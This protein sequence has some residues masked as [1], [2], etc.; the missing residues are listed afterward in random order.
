MKKVALF[1]CYC[2]YWRYSH[3]FIL[4][5]GD[6]HACSIEG[7]A[8]CRSNSLWVSANCTVQ[9]LD[10]ILR[11]NDIICHQ[12]DLSEHVNIKY[13]INT[14]KSTKGDIHNFLA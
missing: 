13:P 3:S 10:S 5:S 4:G 2:C 7:L 1:S 8:I 6:Q 12:N 9:F 14:R 11:V